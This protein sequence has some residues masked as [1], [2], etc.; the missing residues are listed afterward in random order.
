[1]NAV[2]VCLASIQPNDLNGNDIF[3][4]IG[5]FSIMLCIV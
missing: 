5:I 4:P 2:H 3:H 1:M